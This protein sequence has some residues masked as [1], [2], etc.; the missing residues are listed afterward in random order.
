MTIDNLQA[1]AEKLASR[2]YLTVVLRDVTT[3]SEVIYVAMNPE[4]E[5]CIAQGDTPD[6]ARQNLS[7]TR[8]DFI[9]YMLEDEIS[10]PEPQ[11]ISNAVISVS[12][13]FE[14]ITEAKNSDVDLLLK[15]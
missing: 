5:G 4:L 12:T 6:E 1:S 8:I 2:P 13:D 3:D 15:T 11:A 14:S 9:R 7:E 10:I